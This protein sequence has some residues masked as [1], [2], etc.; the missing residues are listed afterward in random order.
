MKKNLSFID[1]KEKEKT[2]L[3]S[4]SYIDQL[5][6]KYISINLV[7]ILDYYFITP[8]ILTSLSFFLGL[9]SS[10]LVFYENYVLAGITFFIN[11]IID[12]VDGPL[13]RYIN[14]TTRI[15]DLYDHI[16]DWVTFILL[17]FVCIQKKFPF[18]FFATVFLLCITTLINTANCASDGILLYTKYIISD[19]MSHQLIN[20]NYFKQLD[21]ACVNIFISLFLIIKGSFII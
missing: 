9:L 17:M 15:G 1:F 20:I 19:K 8:N 18:H 5:I 12:C 11:Y 4:L 14:K 2:R 16:T 10:Y 21:T 7:E 3:L 13:A 6:Y